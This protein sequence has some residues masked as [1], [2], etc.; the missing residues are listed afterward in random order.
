MDLQF[1]IMYNH[2]KE[3]FVADAL[4]RVVFVMNLTTITGVQPMWVQEVLN[5]YVT[6]P[7]TQAM[8]RKLAVHTADEEGIF[9]AGSDQK[10]TIDLDCGE[11]MFA[12]KVYICFSC[13]SIE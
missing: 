11:F 10:S 7:H 1:K 3:N 4:S 2:G 12:Q 8:L 6:D 9:S 5:S 13:V